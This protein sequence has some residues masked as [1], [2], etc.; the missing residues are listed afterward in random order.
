V[1]NSGYVVANDIGMANDIHPVNKKEVGR[2]LALLALKQTYGQK[3]NPVSPE[4]KKV[5]RLGSEL[6]LSF[7]NA[8]GLLIKN[9]KP[10]TGFAIAGSDGKFYWAKARV[11]GV[12][13]TLSSDKVITPVRVRYAYDDDPVV[14]LFNGDGLP[15]GP[16]DASVK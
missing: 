2:R 11:D 3:S 1:K 10:H 13:V 16:I 4:L 9:A 6:V 14:T 7:D 15:A 5:T 12:T 8:T